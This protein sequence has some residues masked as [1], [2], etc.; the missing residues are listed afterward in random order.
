[1]KKKISL[2]Q[3]VDVI[4]RKGR[5][6][7]KMVFNIQRKLAEPYDPKKDHYR[8]LRRA[9]QDAHGQADPKGYLD[10]FLQTVTEPVRA[11]RYASLVRAYKR[12]IGRKKIDRFDLLPVVYEHRGFA[13]RV[14][15]ELGLMIDD[16]PHVLKL[17][18]KDQPLRRE[19]AEVIAALMR[20]VYRDES[21]RYA[22]L[23]V[24]N[25]KLHS[26]DPGGIQVTI[27]MVDAELAYIAQ[28]WQEPFQKA[29]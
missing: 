29:A 18:M 28:L 3:L 23:D 27:A 6:K 13:V 14:N 8:A 26:F 1:L 2:T 11:K 25:A 16:E 7:A 17:Y 19:D 10:N 5:N 12:W 15:P 9:L 4:A 20:H 24:Q 22:V 21:T